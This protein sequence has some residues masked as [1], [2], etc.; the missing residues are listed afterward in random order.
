MHELQRRIVTVLHEIRD[1]VLASAQ[2]CTSRHRIG[3]LRVL[4][5]VLKLLDT[6]RGRGY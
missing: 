2:L 6:L 1:R 5:Q 3:V 4:L